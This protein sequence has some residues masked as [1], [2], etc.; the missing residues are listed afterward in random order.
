MSDKLKILFVDDE[1]D[2]L[3]GYMRM[4]FSMRK[5]WDMEFVLSGKEALEYLAKQETDVVVSDMKMPEM[6]GT[7]LLSKIKEHYPNIIRLILSGHQDLIRIVSSTNL[8]HRF[9]SKPCSTEVLKQNISNSFR[10]RELINNPRLVRLIN[11]IGELPVIPENY[12]KLDELLNSE[13]ISIAVIADFISGDPALTAKILQTV[14]SGFFGLPRR[15]TE[16]QE[17]IGFL[18]T[19]II[20]SLVLYLQA[21]AVK[22]LDYEQRKFLLKIGMHSLRVAQIARSISQSQ[23]LNKQ[24]CNDAF[25]AGILHDIGNLILLRVSGYLDKRDKMLSEGIHILDIEERIIGVTHESA[26]AYL[27]GIWGIPQTIVEAVAFHHK[28][29]K[30]EAKG[31]NILTALH[32]ANALANYTDEEYDIEKLN[33]NWAFLRRQDLEKNLQVWFEKSRKY[34]KEE[35]MF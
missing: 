31:F 33:V 29:E 19:H 35:S 6:D 27:L 30:I 15:I 12:L 34:L 1:K 11:G 2:V 9:L 18:G 3:D 21:F 5:E 13:D 14:N 23:K 28:P 25:T 17:A 20:K 26:G 10:V 22:D 7:E 8:A 4:L 24:D 32:I 16:L